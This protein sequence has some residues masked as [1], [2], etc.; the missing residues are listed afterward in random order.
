MKEITPKTS[1]QNCLK[2][3][4][5]DKEKGSET[6][7]EDENSIENQKESLHDILNYY[8]NAHPVLKTALSCCKSDE[9]FYYITDLYPIYLILQN[10]ITVFD[11]LDFL[12][13]EYLY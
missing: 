8:Q 5:Q 4:L 2:P 6:R 9:E 12:K 7:I 11:D 10:Y 13:I 3:F 1:S